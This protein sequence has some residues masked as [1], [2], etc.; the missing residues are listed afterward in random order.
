[1]DLTSNNKAKPVPPEITPKRFTWL[2]L[3]Q[4]DVTDYT[5]CTQV[6][7]KV[8]TEGEMYN[9]LLALYKSRPDFTAYPQV[10]EDAVRRKC[11]STLQLSIFTLEHEFNARRSRLG[12]DFE[13]FFE[14]H[15]AGRVCLDA[16]ASREVHNALVRDIRNLISKAKNKE[17]A[18]SR[19]MEAAFA[20]T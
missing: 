1:M 6:A 3:G 17:A 13:G 2:P 14:K 4:D 18:D 11:E 9:R 12:L 20:A 5:T 19:A 10:V 7:V 8:N 15:G 16:M